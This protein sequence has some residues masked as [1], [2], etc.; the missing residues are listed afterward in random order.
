MLKKCVLSAFSLS[1]VK[2]INNKWTGY[3]E[4]NNTHKAYVSVRVTV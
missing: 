4:K 3:S 2:I 1:V